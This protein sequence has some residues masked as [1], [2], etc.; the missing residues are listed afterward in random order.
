MTRAIATRLSLVGVAALGA[1]L[2]LILS[3]SG[4][5]VASSTGATAAAS[6]APSTAQVLRVQRS[7]FE[8]LREAPTKADEISDDVASSYFSGL[9]AAGAD[10]GTARGI[11][12]PYGQG[13]VI[14]VPTKDEVCL[15]MPD[16]VPGY[17]ITCVSTEE[18]A[19]GHLAGTFMA[20]P[21][22]TDARS[23]LVAVVPDGAATPTVDDGRALSR[24]SAP[25]KGVVAVASTGQRTVQLHAPDGTVAQSIQLGAEPQGK[26]T[27]DC[28]N[29]R[30][31]EVTKPTPDACDQP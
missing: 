30:I 5:A 9:T 25:V 13:W 27:R 24:L 7:T 31:I 10:L 3:S 23:E 16:T 21:G 19:E 28:G 18:A 6:S 14:P 17:G 15:A 1:V 12:T 29:G 2:V 22:A 11:S 8:L 26:L 4:H 20:P